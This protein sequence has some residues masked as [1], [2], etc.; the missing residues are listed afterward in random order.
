[1]SNALL[2]SLMTLLPF[3]GA[4]LSAFLPRY[5]KRAAVSI[6]CC[7]ALGGLACAVLLYPAV[8]AGVV[9][10]EVEWLPALGLNLIFRLN[11]LSWLFSVLILAIGL[12][13]VIY[14][15]YYM[16]PQDP[17]ARFF[18]YLLAFMGA[19][20]GIVMSGNL[21]QLFMFWE[22][23]SIFSF[24]LIGYWQHSAS[25]RDGARM[26]LT[27]TAMGG[28]ALLVGL[29]LIGNI[30]GSF[31]LDTVLSS[32]DLIK[33]HALYLPIL[34][35]ILTGAL[36]KSA[37]FPFFFWL[38]QAM[39]APTPVSAYLHSATM[40]KAGIFLLIQLWPILAGTNAWMYLV[41]GAGLL[42]LLIGAYVAI[43]QHDLKGLLAYSTISHLG[44]ITLLLGMSSPLALVAAIFHTLN[45]ATFKASLF[46]AVGVIDHETGTRDMRQLSGLLRYM[47]ITGML[48]MIATAAMAGVPLLNG[49]LSK[50]MFLAETVL[51][52]EFMGFGAYVLP[53][54]ATVAS[55]FAVIYSL[56]FI[57]QTFFGP[58]P[59]GLEREPHEPPHLM[60][61]PIEILVLVCLL[62]GMFPERTMGPFLSLAVT[63][64]LGADTPQ[65]SLA[66]WHGLSPAML[67]SLMALF[68]G[69]AIYLVLTSRIHG[70]A[71]GAPVIY[72]MRG[73]QVF[74]F[75][76]ATVTWLAQKLE[77][78]LGTRSLQP[79]LRL[80][81]VIA[82]VV[83]AMAV[84]HKGH[85]MNFGDMP[86]EWP[87]PIFIA[88]WVAGSICAVSAAWYAKYH[89]L[90]S[91]IF[92]GGA[93]LV[94][95]ASFV[96]L[97]APD[98]AKTQLLVE[99][100][101]TVML[102]L[103][104]R[105]LPKRDRKAERKTRNLLRYVSIHSM[106]L[107]IA[108]AAGIGMATLAYFVM[109]QPPNSALAEF[110]IRNA[111]SEAG[112]RNVVNVL[113]VD[114]R[115]LDTL[116]EITV[117][118]IV[119]LIVFA[120]LRRFRP[121]AESLIQPKQQQRQN[122]YDLQRK[123]MEKNGTLDDYMFL[124]QVI[125]DW[126]FPF[127]LVMAV[128]LLLRGH[129]LPGGGFVAGIVMSIAFIMQY[130]AFGVRKTEERFLIFPIYWVGVGLLLSAFVGVGSM[131][132]GYPFLTTYF[133][134]V[135]L[136][137]FG[138][139]PTASA[140]IF[141]V[142]VFVLVVGATILTI[143]ALAHQSIRKPRVL[144]PADEEEIEADSLPALASE[145]TE[146]IATQ[147][148]QEKGR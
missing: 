119:G 90:R 22:L 42:T 117:L 131:V 16:S 88:L 68:F 63:S 32:G 84:L 61:L 67:M 121:A 118:G 96:W 5:A 19:M 17:V 105:W 136:P 55:T 59:V 76:M 1:M 71:K 89:R 78:L 11:G 72:R 86:F 25:A 4:F 52:D 127:V 141:D 93:G 13:V 110:F 103:G 106:D 35:L 109:M 29:V 114:F 14:A 10:H 101:T 46:M 145:S 30:V 120:L 97:S 82:L 146:V 40:V 99:I 48:A 113:L 139:I 80:V 6:A 85:N 79:Q 34:L 70:N 129:D 112:G 45:H 98:L 132:F 54:L 8:T 73:K 128:F 39:S 126:L 58:P 21:I 15:R 142:G 38:P 51:H 133:N 36:T 26:A 69:G 95:A 18:S 111:Y 49:F 24:L 123:D 125:L 27:L 2:L 91:L 104:L 75:V 143:I 20:L 107:I 94:C 134:Y 62:V 137:F 102:L 87:D 140:M 12:L 135:E 53:V 77:G 124:P 56:R 115:A 50:E 3:V 92:L 122:A 44:L 66:I 116:G 47:P 83:G 43:F 64:V 138:K 9:R 65:Y 144:T 37:Q 147:P 108:A 23:T 28:L 74:D 60:R 33:N 41:G 81:T 130:I 7:V 148:D 31:D 57:H 100:V